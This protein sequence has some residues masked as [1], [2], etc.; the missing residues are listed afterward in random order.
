MPRS[1][2]HRCLAAQSHHEKLVMADDP[3]LALTE[4]IPGVR[5]TPAPG[6][7]AVVL[8]HE[9]CFWLPWRRFIPKREAPRLGEGP[10]LDQPTGKGDEWI[11]SL[12]HPGWTGRNRVTEQAPVTG[13]A[14]VHPLYLR[15]A[16]DLLTCRPMP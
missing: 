1:P 6:E 7:L 15:D 13:Y 5:R 3:P 2:Y 11:P 9:E 12:Q 16:E 8:F 4:E 10:Y 14:P